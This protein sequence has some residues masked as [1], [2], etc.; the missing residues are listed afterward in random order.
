M[1]ET[2]L[3]HLAAAVIGA[4]GVGTPWAVA[5]IKKG[6]AALAKLELYEQEGKVKVE[7]LEKKL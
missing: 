1:I 2:I 4:I 6:K 3:T 7:A 5:E